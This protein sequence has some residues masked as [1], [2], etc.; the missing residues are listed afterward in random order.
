MKKLEFDRKKAEE[1]LIKFRRD[2]HQIP[3]IGFDLEKTVK[4]VCSVLDEYGIS[5]EKIVEGS[6]VVA[7]I[8]SGSPGK[9]VGLR[10]DMDALPIKEETDLPFKSE[11]GNMHACGHDC[12]TAIL[13][14]TGIVLN[15]NKD[16]WSGKVKLLFQPSEEKDGGA[17]PMIDAGCLNEPK[18]DYI[19]GQH[20]GVLSGEIEI[21]Q[22]G[23]VPGPM[24]ASL[25]EFTIDFIG[26]GGHGAY[27][28]DT[29]DPIPMAASAVLA[30]QAFMARRVNA[31]DSAVFTI[32]QIHG[33]SQYNIVP[34]KVSINGTVR[35]LNES[36]R[37]LIAE[38]C[39]R[40]CKSTAES[41]GGK[42][43]IDYKF[44]YPALINDTELTQKLIDLSQEAFGE[45]SVKRMEKASMG[46]EDFAY[47]AQEAPACFTFLNTSKECDGVIYPNHNPKFMVDEDILIKG[48]DYF[49]T[50]VGNLS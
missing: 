33:G 38:G 25:D 5:Y 9:T 26:Q 31:L 16:K 48:V 40:I 14:T 27:P 2:L 4:Y 24:M 32:G 13:L 44:G 36:V 49:V 12:H 50:A 28:H 19:L 11:N 22:M 3:E 17:K 10:A 34:N 41:Y 30:L 18:V 47:F 8:D 39:E 7:L 21:G 45:D 43:E 1:N 6:A 46:S 23:F 15:E 37:K 20:V 42:A 35:C 29:I